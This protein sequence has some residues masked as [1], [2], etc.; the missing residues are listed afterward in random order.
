VVPLIVFAVGVGLLALEVVFLVLVNHGAIALP[1][2][3]PLRGAPVTVP[4][5]FTTGR[6]GNAI[7]RATFNDK[8]WHPAVAGAGIPPSRATGMHALRTSSPRCCS[9]RGRA[10]RSSPNTSVTPTRHSRSGST[11]T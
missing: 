5:V 10:S 9:T 2:E 1:W 8:A 6:R 4:L 11:P 7:N 3:D